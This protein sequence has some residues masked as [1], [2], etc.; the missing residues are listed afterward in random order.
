[1]TEANYTADSAPPGAGGPI[2]WMTSGDVNGFFGLMVDN[3]TVMALMAAILI[4]VFQFPADIIYTRMFPGTALGVL[5]GDLVYTWMA[6]RLIQRTGN[7]GVT[8]M[9]LGLDTPSS[10]A[11]VFTV[12]GPAFNAYNDTMPDREAAMMTWYL[13][14]ATMVNIGLIKLVFSFAGKWLQSLIPQAGLLGSLA[15][16]GIALIGLLP[17]V[18][19]F[20][21]PVVGLISLGLVL[22]TLVAGIRLPRNIPGVAVAVLVGTVLH[23]LMP[24]LGLPGGHIADLKE[25]QFVGGLPIPRLDFLKAYGDSLNYL[26]IAFPFAILTVIGGVNVTESARVGGDDFDTRQ[27]LL[28]EAI[29]TL[30]AGICGGVAQSTPYIG[31]PAYKAMG[32]RLGYT[33]LTGLFIG[34]GG[35]LGYISFIVTLIPAAV[36]A[37]ILVFVALDIVVQAFLAT[38]ARHAPAVALAHIPTL[39]RLLAIQ[40]DKHLFDKMPALLKADRHGISEVQT[41]IALGNGFIVTAMLWGAFTA[42]LIDRRLKAAAAYLMVLAAL[43][44]P[45][46]IHSALPSGKMYD[47]RTLDVD[48]RAVPM[49]FA[50]GYATLALI[51]FLLSF[52]KESQEP[53]GESHM[54]TGHFG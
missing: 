51:F 21:L 48:A 16:I 4:N 19:I 20:R 26:P 38:P 36:L 37:P 27:I 39:A 30:L 29:A 15:G 35:I 8:A 13:G 34:L 41:I 9:P 5:F 18:E 14:M 47:P 7:T 33:I 23:Y 22:Y 40:F 1:M 32:S 12:L 42:E 10:I 17:I 31:Q 45:G 3:L 11:M 25:L 44:V 49:L 43:T 2:R 24:S 6:Y 46:I 54:G 53:P 52:T 50:L 28:T